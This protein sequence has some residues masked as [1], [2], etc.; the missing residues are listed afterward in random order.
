MQFT[1]AFDSS[2][3]LLTDARPLGH[4]TRVHPKNTGAD[5]DRR[6]KSKNFALNNFGA[7]KLRK[8]FDPLSLYRVPRRAA[9]RAR[10][11]AAH[12]RL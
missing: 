5:K 7:F 6:Y 4:E 1:D 9:C 3:R 11:G 10:R 2:A 8:L 12:T